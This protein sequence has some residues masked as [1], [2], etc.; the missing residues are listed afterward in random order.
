MGHQ[1]RKL[2]EIIDLFV[3]LVRFSECGSTDSPVR[4]DVNILVEINSADISVVER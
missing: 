1:I 2:D 3:V 4:D